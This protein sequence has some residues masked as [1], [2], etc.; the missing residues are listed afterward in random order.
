M[1]SEALVSKF[2]VGVFFKHN[3]DQDNEENNF[4]TESEGRYT[5]HIAEE[6]LQECPRITIKIGEEEVSAILDTGFQLTL[7]NENLYEKIKKEETSILSFQPNTL[8][9]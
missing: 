9:W 3:A 8:H 2:N 4:G 5:L 6:K 1:E 7:M